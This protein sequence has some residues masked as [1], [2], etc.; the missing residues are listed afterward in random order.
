M[1]GRI[2]RQSVEDDGIEMIVSDVE[3]VAVTLGDN[4]TVAEKLAQG[5]N[6]GLQRGP[7][8]GRWI[9]SP[10]AVDEYLAAHPTVGVEAQDRQEPSMRRPVYQNLAIG[11]NPQGPEY[12]Y[13]QPQILSALDRFSF[14]HR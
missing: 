12:I 6:V 4:G 1:L 11:M 10:E 2:G 13:F 3:P 7:G 5:S 14:C 8:G 9:L